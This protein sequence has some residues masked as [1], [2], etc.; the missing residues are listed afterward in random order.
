[1]RKRANGMKVESFDDM[2]GYG[3]LMAAARLPGIHGYPQFHLNEERACRSMSVRIESSYCLFGH[4]GSK[5][6]L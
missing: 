3:R 2:K 5:I 1:M 4:T 6:G